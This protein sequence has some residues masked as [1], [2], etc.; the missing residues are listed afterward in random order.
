MHIGHLGPSAY[1]LVHHRFDLGVLGDVALSTVPVAALLN[2]RCVGIGWPSSVPPYPLLDNSGPVRRRRKASHT[3][4]V[5]TCTPPSHFVWRGWR[6][7]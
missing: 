2:M 6:L 4:K 1:M 3:A 5:L 7:E